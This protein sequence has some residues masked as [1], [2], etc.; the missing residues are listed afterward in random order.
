MGGVCLQA[1]GRKET[2]LIFC[3]DQ[4]T[5]T[6]GASEGFENLMKGMVCAC[7]QH[8]KERPAITFK[9]SRCTVELSWNFLKNTDAQ[10]FIVFS[11]KLQI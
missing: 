11:P 2:L 6:L 8:L 1:W 5:V 3:L 10:V 7:M 9:K 4:C